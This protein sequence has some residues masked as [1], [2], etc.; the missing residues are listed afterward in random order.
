MRLNYRKQWKS[1]DSDFNRLVEN[2]DDPLLTKFVL[3][4]TGVLPTCVLS[5]WTPGEDWKSFFELVDKLTQIRRE[6]STIVV[7]TLLKQYVVTSKTSSKMRNALNLLNK[8]EHNIESL[9]KESFRVR[10]LGDSVL[11]PLSDSPANYFQD[12][13]TGLT[14]FSA[15]VVSVDWV[16]AQQS[17]D[18]PDVIIEAEFDWV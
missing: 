3:V 17:I 16:P 2:S 11:L 1:S 12:K 14:A 7:M 4:E 9:I 5:N 15:T 10:G 8:N 18:G 6:K 13:A